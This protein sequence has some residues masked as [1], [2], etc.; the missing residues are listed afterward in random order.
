MATAQLK[1]LGYAS[2]TVANGLEVLEALSRI[3]YDIILMDCQMPELDGYET[4]RQVRLRGG[5]QPYI[6]AMTA[7]AMQGDRELCLATGMDNYISKPMRIADLK[8]ALDEAASPAS[9]S[10]D[11]AV[12][13][14]LREL[15]GE[16]SPE[17]LSEL[18]ELFAASTPPLLSQARDALS[19]PR[20]LAVI[21]HTIKG[22]CSNFGARAMEALC[23]QLEQLDGEGGSA[24]AEN[25]VAA[26]EREFLNVCAALESH[27]PTQQGEIIDSI[28]ML[29]FF[30]K[31]VRLP[32]FRQ[33]R[34][35][36]RALARRCL[37]GS[38]LLLG[39]QNKAGETNAAPSRV[40]GAKQASTHRESSDVTLVCPSA[41]SLHPGYPG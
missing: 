14:N 27:C 23:L 12:L 28:T 8:S 16:D 20:E 37:H 40:A 25:L 24:A 3:P 39:Y 1:K 29:P 17:I 26:I 15:T 7:N 10:I 9:E 36:Q 5:H 32:A 4:T 33:G 19:N 18:I 31:R 35:F 13:A 30:A 21:A 41:L 2:D 34:P 11:V 6:I 22:S 38:F